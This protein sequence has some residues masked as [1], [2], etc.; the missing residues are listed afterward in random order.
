MSGRRAGS[1]ARSRPRVAR[2]PG[3]PPASRPAPGPQRPPHPVVA[4]AQILLGVGLSCLMA[5]LCLGA[6]GG[7]VVLVLYLTK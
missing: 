7:V 5:L 6:L 2:P 4:A 3:A 1:G